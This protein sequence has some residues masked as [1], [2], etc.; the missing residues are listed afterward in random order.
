MCQTVPNPSISKLMELLYFHTAHI[1]FC[2]R[3]R[4]DE[5]EH[6]IGPQV[7]SFVVKQS[8]CAY[9]ESVLGLHCY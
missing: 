6:P 8:F 1:D 3:E 2:L 9:G 5:G 7:T 4:I